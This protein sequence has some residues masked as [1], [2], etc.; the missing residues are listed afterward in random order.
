MHPLVTN[1]QALS[2]DELF[3][4]INDLTGRMHKAYRFG[5]SDAVQ[6]L[7]MILEEYNWESRRRQ[8]KAMQELE[9][10]TRKNGDFKDFINIG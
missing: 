6:Q 8:E 1:L 5:Y 2:D 9:E 10:L 4:K 3:T 7:Q